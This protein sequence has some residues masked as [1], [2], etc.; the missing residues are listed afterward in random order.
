MN[1]SDKQEELKEL[2]IKSYIQAYTN[3]DITIRDLLYL[4]T[5]KLNKLV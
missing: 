1:E 3:K 2:L 4:I 5:E